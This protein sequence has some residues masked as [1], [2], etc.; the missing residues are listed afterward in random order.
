[1]LNIKGNNKGKPA[2][3]GEAGRRVIVALDV[4]SVNEAIALV[5]RLLEFTDSFKVGMELFYA[6]GPAVIDKIRQRGGR[7]FLDLKLHDIPNTVGAAAASLSRLGV[8]MFNVHASGGL[9]M[10][11]RAAQSVSGAVSEAALGPVVGLGMERPRV[12]AVTVLTSIDDRSLRGELGV[13]RSA[14]EQ[15]VVLAGLAKEA[16]LDGVVASPREAQAI[17]EACGPEFIIVTP[18]VRPAWAEAGDQRRVASPA[19]AFRAGADYIVVGRPVTQAPDPAGAMKR[20]IEEVS[21]IIDAG[22]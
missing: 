9:D 12:L 11:K 19:E 21:G 6:A 10:M 14:A 7:V 3:P 15:V 16:G 1:M 8:W 5:D 20:I 22:E 18:G 13:A 17:R 4:S 2:P